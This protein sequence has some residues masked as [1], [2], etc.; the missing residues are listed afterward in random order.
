MDASNVILQNIEFGRYNA[1]L[2]SISQLAP[3]NLQ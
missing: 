3:I 1:N 2:R